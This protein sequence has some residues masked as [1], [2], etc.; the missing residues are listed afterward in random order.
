MNKEK[1]V[2]KKLEEWNVILFHKI[3]NM[4]NKI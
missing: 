1:D 4:P 2:F 3:K